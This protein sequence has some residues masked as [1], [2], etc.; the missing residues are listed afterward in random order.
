M[1]TV[2][3]GYGEDGHQ[4]STLSVY[5]LPHLLHTQGQRDERT[6]KERKREK[7]GGPRLMHTHELRWLSV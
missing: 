7:D 1:R 3:A 6:V 4:V 5:N 2:R